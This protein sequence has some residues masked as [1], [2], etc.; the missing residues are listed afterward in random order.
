MED[1]KA[2]LTDPFEGEVA[3]MKGLISDDSKRLPDTDRVLTAFVKNNCTKSGELFRKGF[4]RR[5]F[6][7]FKHLEDLLYIIIRA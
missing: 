5:A 4:Y 3:Q 6:I 7:H 1:G 2:G